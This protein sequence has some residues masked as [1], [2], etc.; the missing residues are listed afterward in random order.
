M[1]KQIQEL[2]CRNQIYLQSKNQKEKH[3]YLFMNEM[4]KHC[5]TYAWAWSVGFCVSTA[6]FL[7]FLH[8]NANFNIFS[9]LFSNENTMPLIYIEDLYIATMGHYWLNYASKR[10]PSKVDFKY[11][12]LSSNAFI[13][14]PFDEGKQI[15]IRPSTSFLCLSVST[16]RFFSVLQS[17]RFLPKPPSNKAKNASSR[18][19]GSGSCGLR[20]LLGSVVCIEQSGFIVPA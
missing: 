5:Q 14:L 20:G 8:T 4:W 17:Q 6:L 7:V 11:I 19:G 2:S 13:C 1:S 16:V 18:K 9:I 15:T 3:N 10:A 12:N